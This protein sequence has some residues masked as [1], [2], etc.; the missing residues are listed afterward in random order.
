[1]STPDSPRWCEQRVFLNYG[2]AVLS[3]AVALSIARLLQI[4]F[5]FEPLVLF[6]CALM[7]SGWFGGIKPGLV[8]VALSLLA[9]HYFFLLPIHPS[10]IQTEIPRLLVAAGTSLLIVFLSAAQGN[11]T[12]ALRESE[13]RYHSLFEHMAEGVVYL[14]LL[15]ENGEPR[16]AIYLAVNPAWEK[17]TGLKN[18]V[19]RKMSEV[20]PG[21]R[22]TRPEPF[23]RVSRVAVTGRSER[24]ETYST[25]LKK[26][27]SISAYCPWKEHVIVVH[28]DITERKGAQDQ[29][30]LVI[31]TIPAMAWSLR[32]DGVVDFLNKRWVDYCGLT[33]EQYVRDPTGPVHPD[34]IPRVW[35][36][37]RAAMAAGESSEDEMRLRLADGEYRWFL[38]RTVPLRDEHGGIVKWLGFSIDI[39]DRREAEEALRQ[40]EER[41]AAFMDNLPGYAWMKDLQGRYVYVNQ[42]VRGLSGYGSLGKTDAQIWPADLAA[43]YRAHDQQVIAERKPLHTVERYWHEGKQRCMAGSKFPIFD[44]TGAVALVGGAGVDITERIEAEEAL[45][46]SEH[47]LQT[48]LR[49]AMDGFWRAD[50]QGRFLE[51]NEAYCRMSAYSEQE[52]LAMSIS[53]VEA[54]EMPSAVVAHIHSTMARGEDRFESRHRR[55]DGSTFP[56][57]V[58]AQYKT[59]DGGQMVAFVRDITE[60]KQA[61]EALREHADRLRQ[62]TRRLME[63]EEQERRQFARELHDRI[64][65]NLSALT[66]NLGMVRT[67]LSRSSAEAVG[68]RLSDSETLLKETVQQVRDVMA[69]LRPP[70]LDE[71]GLLAALD[72]HV[73]LVAN[74][75]NLVYEVSGSDPIPRLSP[76]VEIALFRIA[77]EALNN[78]IKHAQASRIA[79]ALRPANGRVILTVMDDGAGFDASTRRAGTAGL[80]MITMRERAEAIGARLSVESSRGK[81][82]RVTIDVPKAS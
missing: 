37:W 57:E 33:L 19:G 80:G 58:S 7:F 1:M 27:L 12:T 3:V 61:D 65:P 32:P 64:G 2:A 10:S 71:L 21:F 63:L 59:S 42:M 30:R 82:T 4:H 38:V 31:D 76:I 53:D 35:K 14:R 52:L 77:Q 51:V 81:G 50:V 70:E 60:R 23:E 39:E 8:A 5:H 69:D 18:V 44:K 46:E 49:T 79:L 22:E 62:L 40:S 68:A 73:C 25:P 56:V 28:D 67:A 9:F 43:E 16:D 17:M 11:A 72:Q 34:D 36:N 54:R 15:F 75:A 6:I 41:F 13:Q 78:V 55:K 74:R 26:W 47:R 24:F 20:V 66:L 29:L 45:R 48:I